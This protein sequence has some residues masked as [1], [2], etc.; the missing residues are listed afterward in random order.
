[1]A[2]ADKGQQAR[3]GW[4]P[5]PRRL[6][7]LS[8]QLLLW[9]ILPLGIV[10]I[11]LSLLSITRHR[12]AMSQLIED[13][14]RGLAL[15]EANRL[16]REIDARAAGLAEA[17]ESAPASLSDLPPDL[18]ARFTSG[19]ALVSETGEVLDASGVLHPWTAAPEARVLAARSAAVP[20]AQFESHFSSAGEPHLLVGA[21]A[22]EGVRCW[23]RF[24]RLRSG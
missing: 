20:G 15:G 12:D 4:R 3:G 18:F 22:G 16:A 14:N 24:P 11:V 6:R 2:S 7:G 23:A 13:R 10:L 9:I 8:V 19:L 21:A 1:V 17:G 5:R